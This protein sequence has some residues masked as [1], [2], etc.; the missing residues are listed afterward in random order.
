[1]KKIKVLVIIT[2]ILTVELAVAQSFSKLDIESHDITYYKV[3]GETNPQ[4][5]VLYGR[6][7]S[8][9]DIIFGTVIPYGKIWR[10]GANEA[11]E[12]KLYKDVMFGNK[13]VKAGTYVLFTIPGKDYWTI[14]LNT[15]T[16]TYGTF[17]YNPDKDVARIKVPAAK[18]K[19]IDIFSIGFKSK[20]YGT[21][22][23][24]AWGQTRVNIPLYIE[25]KLLTRL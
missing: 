20:S 24:L 5:K 19:P 2:L 13:Y 3:E 9:N 15:N 17:F 16:D 11:T 10:T 8:E 4:I 21:Q 22:M 14:I 25:E 7:K 12:I 6:P 1:M 23:V 18:S